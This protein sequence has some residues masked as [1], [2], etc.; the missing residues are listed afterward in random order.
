LRAAGYKAVELEGSYTGY[1]QAQKD[2]V[3][4]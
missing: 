4:A 2:A 1:V 3:T